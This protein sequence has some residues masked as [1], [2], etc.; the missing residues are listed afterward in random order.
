LIC[1]LFSLL[2]AE[3]NGEG[4]H[5]KGLEERERGIGGHERFHNESVGW[6]VEK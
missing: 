1:I 5:Y 2:R 4:G 3:R 6:W